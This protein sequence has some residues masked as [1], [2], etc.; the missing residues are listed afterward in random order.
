MSAA[1]NTAGLLILGTGVGLIYAAVTGQSPMEELRKALTS[2]SLDGAPSDRSIRS[3]PVDTDG[4]FAANEARRQGAQAPSVDLPL[5]PLNLVP[6]GQGNHRLIAPA[7]AA[8]KQAERTYGRT[9]TVTDSVRSASSQASSY[10]ANPS[11]FGS[12]GTSY[13]VKGAAVDV[14]LPALGLS[15]KGSDPAGWLADPGYRRLFN[16]MTAAG[17]CNYQI[18][19]GTTRG[20][21]PEP[22]HYSWGG[23]G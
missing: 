19:S 17:W 22:W 3:T 15:P 11:R 16:A 12:A 21:T 6:I 1:T 23:C 13:H 14:N 10:A 20:R 4:S 7:A 2:G 8:F 18:R 9:I 5:S